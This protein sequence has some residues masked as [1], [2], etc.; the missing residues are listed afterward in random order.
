M[1][2]DWGNDV[3]QATEDAIARLDD[4]NSGI[5]NASTNPKGL[6]GGGHISNFPA[7]LTDTATVANGFSTFADLMSNY[8][9]AAAAS[10]TEAGLSSDKLSGTST[11]SV[12]LSTGTKSFSTQTSRAWPAGTYL[13]ISSNA[14]PATNW[15]VLQVTSYSGSS[16][17]GTA[18]QF[19]G[20]GSKSDWTIRPT[21]VP[22]RALG[23]NYVWST[24]TT[25]SDP[26]T[27]K[28]KLN[29][30]PGSATAIYI[31]ETDSEGNALGT[32]IATWD[33]S[34]ST[35]RGR[36]YIQNTTQRTNFAVL[37]ITSAVTDN[38]TWNTLGVT[39]VASGGT[40][41]D[42][43]QVFIV[44]IPYGNAGTTG[45]TGPTG[46]AGTTGATGPTGTAGTVGS[47]GPAGLAGPT[48][49]P[50]WTFDSATLRPIRRAT[51]SG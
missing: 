46:P 1:A 12:T 6:K 11:S 15:M 49:A 26:T 28:V 36:I 21:G 37:D 19:S 31:S 47:I 20:S 10:A 9:T 27:G 48:T 4:Y 2:F 43:A 39:S 7:A 32:L 35:P 38:G 5:F 24:D 16:L 14:S 40:L 30:A 13:L 50:V 44:V 18:V 25:T 34:T 33:D 23:F 41:T 3:N 22:G 29:A 8:A 17:T 51:N 45:P 42:G